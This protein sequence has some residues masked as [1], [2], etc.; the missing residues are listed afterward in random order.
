M[1]YEL[2]DTETRNLIETFESETDALEA[3][4][5]LMAVNGSVYPAALAIAFE[6]DQ[7]ETRLLGSG[8]ELQR[9]AQTSNH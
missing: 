6:D 7:G 5:Q 8:P 1:S 9:L 2:W 4:R 3:A